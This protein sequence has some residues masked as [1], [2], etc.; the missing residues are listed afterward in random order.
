N[1]LTCFFP[2][3]SHHQ[4][5]RSPAAGRRASNFIHV[6]QV[7]QEMKYALSSA[8]LLAAACSLLSPARVQA[9]DLTTVLNPGFLKIDAEVDYHFL[10]IFRF[11]GESKSRFSEKQVVYPIRLHY[12]LAQGV[13][14]AFT[15]P[16][17]SRIL[18]TS[19]DQE[20]LIDRAWDGIGDLEGGT[21]FKFM[22][23]STDTPAV[24][25]ESLLKIPTGHSRFRDYLRTLYDENAF[26][27]GTDTAT[28]D[29]ILKG[30]FSMFLDPVELYLQLRIDVRGADDFRY[31][32]V[33]EHIDYGNIVSLSGGAEM[34]LLDNLT[35]AAEALEIS[36]AASVWTRNGTNALALAGDSSLLMGVT[37]TQAGVSLGN[38][39]E[40]YVGPSVIWGF[41]PASHLKCSF[42][43]GL[44]PDADKFRAM[45]SI[46]TAFPVGILLDFKRGF[47]L[48]SSPVKAPV[49]PVMAD[50]PQTVSLPEPAEAGN[51][52]RFIKRQTDKAERARS[53]ENFHLALMEL[54]QIQILYPDYEPAKQ[55]YAQIT[56]ERTVLT[57]KSLDRAAAALGQND[58]L[59]AVKAWRETLQLDPHHHTAL[60][61][62]RDF[63]HDIREEAKQLYLKGME[64]YVRAEYAQAINAWKTALV[65]DPTNAKYKDSI[66]Q[67]QKKIKAL[68]EINP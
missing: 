57:Q 10:E 18:S 27:S 67:T 44:T 9:T 8:C 2:A 48:F 42:L 14:V 5:A 66:A 6:G 30:I 28:F 46:T 15:L 56:L 55:Q 25:V 34:D 31:Q 12:G 41:L 63:D 7:S 29:L 19:S 58:L 16:V 54:N 11:T 32:G 21:K 17:S 50:L 22:S 39:T 4:H 62:L 61:M 52:R 45:A 35:L 60:G 51:R 13:E 26:I 38:T 23:D 24:F 49:S 43:A 36:S 53:Q 65:F 47:P 20:D 59:A 37:R 1:W 33:H 40:L 3:H 68:K 64:L